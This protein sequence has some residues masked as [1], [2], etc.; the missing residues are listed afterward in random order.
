MGNAGHIAALLGGPFLSLGSGE[1]EL[2][3][4]LLHLPFWNADD[5]G[6]HLQY[7]DVLA[8]FCFSVKDFY[9]SQLW[10]WNMDSSDQTHG[11]M[12]IIHTPTTLS[13]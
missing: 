8:G 5:W 3:L 12:N 7:L 13:W 10:G 11:I 6:K 2:L 9:L 4:A 1:V